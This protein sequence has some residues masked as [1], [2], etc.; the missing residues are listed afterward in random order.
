LG[1]VI[2]NAPQKGVNG[3]REDGDAKVPRKQ[4]EKTESK[5]SKIRGLRVN[6]R[7]NTTGSGR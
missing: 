7:K 4:E 5:I 3:A 6:T 2:Q 1:W